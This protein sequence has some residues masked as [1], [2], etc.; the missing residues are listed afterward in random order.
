MLPATVFPLTGALALRET[1]RLIRELKESIS[2]TV[3]DLNNV[4]DRQKA[5]ESDLHDAHTI[6]DGLKD[7]VQAMEKLLRDKQGDSGAIDP[8]K[9]AE[10]VRKELHR[11]IVDYNTRAESLTGTLHS[12]IDRNLAPMIA[13]E[14]LGGPV[15]G[16]RIDVPIQ[17]LETGYTASGKEKKSKLNRKSVGDPRQQRID[18]TV[19]GRPSG[20][21]KRDAAGKE[22]HDL[23]DSLFAAS[24]ASS[25]INTYI[26]IK[27]ESAAVRFLTR[28]R[29]AQFH[30][31]D[32]L[33]L[34]LIDFAREFSDIA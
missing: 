31:H 23:V 21:K 12:F 9:R 15:A 14:D 20:I 7:R 32:S 3:R 34:R 33:H 17:A 30:P 25:Y 22:L 24:E 5:E 13:A 11:K 16:N 19:D 29:I 2:S 4:R 18:S 6:N 8:A 26:N 10:V 27:E 28:A 1:E